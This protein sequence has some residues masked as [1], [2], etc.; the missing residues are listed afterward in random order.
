MLRLVD[1]IVPLA[2]QVNT[3]PSSRYE[4]LV[5]AKDCD[6]LMASSND[7][8]LLPAGR[9]SMSTV[10]VVSYCCSSGG[11]PHMNVKLTP[12]IIVL[13]VALIYTPTNRP[14]MQEHI[15]IYMVHNLLL[16]WYIIRLRKYRTITN[17]VS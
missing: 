3:S 10:K 16:T 15:H 4:V 14:E 8:T 2:T 7:T 6:P 13:L 11:V 17:H 1:L 12:S 9:S 5:K